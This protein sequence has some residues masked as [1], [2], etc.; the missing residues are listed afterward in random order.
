MK[1]IATIS[2]TCLMVLLVGCAGPRF[3]NEAQY[4]KGEW[5]G[6]AYL[7]EVAKIKRDK[8]QL[9]FDK[10]VGKMAIDK[11]KTQPVN[12]KTGEREEEK[13][14]EGIVEN[15]SRYYMVQI[16][17]R[18]E[19]GYE[20]KSYVLKPGESRVDNLLPG[21][22]CVTTF[23]NG[24][25]ETGVKKFTSGPRLSDYSGKKYHWFVYYPPE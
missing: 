2:F 1:K 18:H 9:A 3:G 11:L 16:D 10:E 23:V 24:R 7:H 4:D 19:R 8:S 14:Y 5:K 22:Y 25:Q 6:S 12:S 13:R 17:I 20:V 21:N 15:L